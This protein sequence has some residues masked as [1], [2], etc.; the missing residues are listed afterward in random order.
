LLFA[1]GYLQYPHDNRNDELN[2]VQTLC[3]IQWK[4]LNVIANMVLGRSAVLPTQPSILRPYHGTSRKK[5]VKNGFDNFN[6][7]V[8]NSD[9]CYV[10]NRPTSYGIFGPTFGDCQK[11]GGFS[12]VPYLLL[13]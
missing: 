12:V 11:T 13:A 10:L 1:L 6:R 3:A 7:P 9:F 5:I 4:L 8:K 2:I